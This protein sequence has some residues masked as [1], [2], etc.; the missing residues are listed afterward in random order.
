MFKRFLTI[1]NIQIPKCSECKNYMP[2]WYLDFISDKNKCTKF[3]YYDDY[4]GEKRYE[5]VSVCRSADSKCGFE[6]KYFVKDLDI[7]KKKMLHYFDKYRH[8]Y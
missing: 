4:T 1:K 8:M 3:I 2:I 7:H 6:G 5:N